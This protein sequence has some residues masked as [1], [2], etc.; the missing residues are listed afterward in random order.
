MKIELCYATP[1]K[2]VIEAFLLPEGLT[3]GEALE[4][5]SVKHFF[6]RNFPEMSQESLT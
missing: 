6:E 2:Q 1:T 5:I 4:R 3:L